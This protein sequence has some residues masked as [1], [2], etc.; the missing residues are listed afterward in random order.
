MK[1]VSRLIAPMLL[2][3]VLFTACGASKSDSIPKAEASLEANSSPVEEVGESAGEI[4]KTS[5]DENNLVIQPMFTND[6]VNARTEGSVSSEI[7]YIINSSTEVGLLEQVDDWSKILFEGEVSFVASKYLSIDKPVVKKRIVIDAGH[8]AKGNSEREPN[9]PGSE[10]MKAKVSSGTTGV[11]TGV[12]E[13]ELNLA[14]TLKLRDELERRGYEVM[15]VRDKHEVNISNVERAMFA[16][17]A[18]ADC[19]IRIHANGSENRSVNGTLTIC[20]TSSNP[21]STSSY[22]DC[23]RLSDEILSGIVEQ[24][25]SQNSGIWETDTMTG[26][27]WSNVVS[28]IVEMGYMSN[29]SEDVLLNTPTYQDKIVEGIANGLDNYF[30]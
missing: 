10:T 11:S 14:V 7:R 21:Y 8:Q 26:I 12:R 22:E 15:L 5:D 4:E 13:Y 17:N 16:N 9:G 1:F 29:P 20:Q 6:D 28:T 2:G 24:T 3:L 18:K 23:Y 25:G 30:K 27:N 19:F